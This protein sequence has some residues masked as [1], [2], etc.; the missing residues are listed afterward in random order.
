MSEKVLM[1]DDESDFL[2]VMRERLASRGID[3]DT[4]ESPAD[5]IDQI[6]RESYD[7]VILDLQM[8]GMDGIEA[9]KQ[10]KAKRPELQIILLTGH[11]SVE[12]G[13]E[14]IKLGAMDFIEKPAD[15]ATISEKI[16][17]AKETK[18]LIVDE[19]NK[20]RY[21]EILRRYGV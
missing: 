5:A 20:E 21:M 9:L 10:M 12:T 17:K 15:L 11:G 19:M 6:G 3:V 13:V 4:S 8:P 18:M 2:D 1:V 16:K 14:A 7:A